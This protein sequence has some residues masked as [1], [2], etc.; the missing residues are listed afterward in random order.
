MEKLRGLRAGKDL[1]LRRQGNKKSRRGGML[2]QLILRDSFGKAPDRRNPVLR[3]RLG[4]NFRQLPGSE[5]LARSRFLPK[6]FIEAGYR[7]PCCPA[8]GRKA[9]PFDKLPR[10]A[11]R[12][13]GTGG[14]DRTG[15][16]G[17]SSLVE[18]VKEAAAREEI[19][20]E[21]LVRDAVENRLSRAEWRK[22]VEF[23]HRNARE[24]GLKQRS[25]Y[26]P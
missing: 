21:E 16:Q 15:S 3:S 14:A 8:M 4:R 1:P 5:R 20:P 18:K 7:I 17:L 10:Q 2:V 22:T 26:L 9:D 13:A 24:P 11:P 25:S 12:R 23:G 19:T 6:S